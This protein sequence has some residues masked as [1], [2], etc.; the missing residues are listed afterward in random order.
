MRRSRLDRRKDFELF[1][2]K[3]ETLFRDFALVDIERSDEFERTHMLVICPGGRRDGNN[4]RVVEVFWG[5]RGF[6]TITFGRNWKSLPEYGV[7]LMFELDDSGR[8]IIALFPAHTE[9]RKPIESSIT[10]WNWLDPKKLS[11]R[12]FV[13]RL[14]NDF[15]AYMAVTSLDGTPT[16]S[17]RIRISWL[18]FIKHQVVNNTWMP[19]KITTYSKEI[20]KYSLTV[21]LSGCL[22]L[23]VTKA[24]ESSDSSTAKKV[25]NIN[26]KL[27]K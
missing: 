4:N 9:K 7:T 15:M 18:R 8:V 5:Q 17:Q 22:L 10:L 16:I 24:C 11:N 25:Y 6:E 26:I 27:N 19:R 21:G 1:Y 3:S 12:I 13:G 2:Q 23:L 14:W 20:I